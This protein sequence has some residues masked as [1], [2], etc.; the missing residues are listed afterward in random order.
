MPTS[1]KK[2]AS[3]YENE[4]MQYSTSKS[5]LGGRA[6]SPY[7]FILLMSE[8]TLFIEWDILKFS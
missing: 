7:H 6:R 5:Q 4:N 3:K 8:S 1:K 2:K